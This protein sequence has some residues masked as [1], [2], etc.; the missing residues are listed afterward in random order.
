MWTQIGSCNNQRLKFKFE[1]TQAKKNTVQFISSSFQFTVPK[2]K[3]LEIV[4]L[5]IW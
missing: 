5:H 1:K 2:F 4:E 3:D